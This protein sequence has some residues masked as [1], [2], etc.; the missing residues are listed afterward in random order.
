M[1]A[2]LIG[3]AITLWID[4][5]PENAAGSAPKIDTSTTSS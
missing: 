5:F 3:I 4:W 1:F 2:S